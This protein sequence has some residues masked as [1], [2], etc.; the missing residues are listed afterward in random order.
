MSDGGETAGRAGGWGV[1]RVAGVVAL[2]VLAGCGG[3]AGPGTPPTEEGTLTP[4]PLPETPPS[5]PTEEP[6][7]VTP[8]PTST[9]GDPQGAVIAPGVSESG[10][11]APGRLADAHERALRNVTYQFVRTTT[12]TGGDST[13]LNVSRTLRVDPGG[14]PYRYVERVRSAD[15][16]P[17]ESKNR[18]EVWSNGVPVY[19]IG[20]EDVRYRVGTVTGPE[21]AV[22]DRTGR[23]RLAA[24][25]AGAT[26][27]TVTVRNGPD[28]P[29]TIETRLPSPEAVVTVPNAV[30]APGP[31]ALRVVITPSGRVVS[32]RL[33]Y[34]A[35]V[36][37]EPVE[38]V[39]RGRFRTLNGT[40]TQPGWVDDARTA[41]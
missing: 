10:V 17:I 18:V 21:G 20:I 40:V 7:R 13:L 2:L 12:V 38:V 39:H 31:A 23:D 35:T 28:G 15:G 25:Y 22:G 34:A 41:T 14:A 32:Y 19:R 1:T 37:G 9:V 36:D 24:L 3:A 26:E 29:H 6:P 11:F 4:A 16:Y 33:R 30:S 27:W 8:S 5:T